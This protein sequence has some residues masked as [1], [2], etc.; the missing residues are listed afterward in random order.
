[1]F[2]FLSNVCGFIFNNFIPI[3]FTL[4]LIGI[5]FYIIYA[6]VFSID[7]LPEKKKKELLDYMKKQQ[8]EEKRKEEERK[9]WGPIYIPSYTYTYN[10]TPTERSKSSLQRLN[11]SR[12]GQDEVVRYG[13]VRKDAYGNIYNA[14]NERIDKAAVEI[15]RQTQQMKQMEQNRIYRENKQRSCDKVWGKK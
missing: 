15:Q 8:E 12:P 7:K 4:L 6:C 1:M 10:N 13:A 11:E 2:K 14:A 5:V 9:A 3:I